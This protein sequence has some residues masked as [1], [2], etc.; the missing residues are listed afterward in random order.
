MK[1]I[2][3]IL[4][5]GLVSFLSSC[6]DFLGTTP[7]NRTVIDTPEKVGELLVSAYPDQNHMMFCYNMSDDSAEKD[8]SQRFTLNAEDGYL[9]NDFRNV[10]QDTPDIYWNSCYK[11]IM[12]ANHAIEYI[13]KFKDD[14]G[15]IDWKYRAFYGEALIARAYCH[16]MLVN[17][18]SKPYN[19]STSEADMGIPYVTKPE[20][21]VFVK[22][23]RSTVAK[24]Y[25]KIEADL[26]EGLKFI[27]DSAYKNKRLHWNINASNTFAAR[28][29]AQVGK[30]DEV[31]KY[32][33]A[34]LTENPASMLRDINGKY[35]EFDYNET[36][37]NWGKTEEA[38]NFL[39]IPQYSYWFTNLFGTDKYGLI[40]AYH[41]QMFKETFVGG[42][43]AWKVYGS[44][45]NIAVAKWGYH[46]EKTDINSDVGYFM[47]MNSVVDAEEALLLR[48]EANIMLE[49]YDEAIEDIDTYLSKRVKSYSGTTHKATDTKINNFY[50][51][52]GIYDKKLDP[53]YGLKDDKQRVYM[54]CVVDLR[55]REFYA[56]GM[57]WFDLLR[58]NV[59]V[60]HVDW[61][62][63]ERF[64]KVDDNRR[65]LQIPVGARNNGIPANPR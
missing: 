37:V 15:N 12:N 47:I 6:D 46:Q 38:C 39:V 44:H 2:K 17:L 14:K 30:F 13:E 55:R 51:N 58:F 25:E 50:A 64:L 32:T 11:A 26:V 41:D 5:L 60:K 36:L 52:N 54:N 31:L 56:R 23:E 29:Y 4:F 3:Y 8:A 10:S 35:S 62:G 61:G 65:Q 16:F 49:K 27:D 28:F 40:D 1:N 21:K 45:P 24:V 22:Y 34:A 43:W 20:K 42:M 59:D 19:N 48:V 18:W 9:W 53:F 7:D 33:N 63:T 57:R